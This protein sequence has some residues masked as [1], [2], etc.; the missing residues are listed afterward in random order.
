MAHLA[1]LL[2]IDLEMELQRS[3]KFGGGGA[4][5]Y[6]HWRWNDVPRAIMH[7]GIRP[8]VVTIADPLAIAWTQDVSNYAARWT[9]EMQDGLPGS[10]KEE[11]GEEWL[12]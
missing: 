3:F 6:P 12:S 10:Q 7:A 11:R 8:E 1:I 2:D 5:N 9:A 4:M